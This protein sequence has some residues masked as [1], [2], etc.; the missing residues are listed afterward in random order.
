MVL[1]DAVKA[2]AGS[3]AGIKGPSDNAWGCCG[4]LR[5]LSQISS[6][7]SEVAV[8]DEVVEVVVVVVVVVEVVVVVVVV[9]V[10]VGVVELEVAVLVDAVKAVVGLGTRKAS[11][12]GNS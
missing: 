6:P 5:N 3:G 7:S 9:V 12:S 1:V 4:M 2:V 10:P 8:E 11:P